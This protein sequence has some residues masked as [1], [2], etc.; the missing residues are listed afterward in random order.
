[1]GPGPISV[2]AFTHL[3]QVAQEDHALVEWSSQ[4]MVKAL[5]GRD[6]VVMPRK[7]TTTQRDEQDSA[8]RLFTSR[9]MIWVP[10]VTL[11]TIGA[12]TLFAV[13]AGIG[14]ALL[15]SG[16]ALV[17][18]ASRLG[19]TERTASHRRRRPSRP[20]QRHPIRLEDA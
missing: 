6:A 18:G 14:W 8:V 4:P 7:S 12:I 15:L 19:G 1:M 17:A 20:S 13:S 9:T 5:P 2:G 10:A 3:R 16:L 11:V